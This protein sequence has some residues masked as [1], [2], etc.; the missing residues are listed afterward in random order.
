MDFYTISTLKNLELH[1]LGDRYFCLA[2]FYLQNEDYKNFFL[3]VRK[4]FPSAWIT[5]DNSS[6]EHSLVTEEALLSVVEELQ[7]NEVISPDV[8]FNKDQT[9][10]N[11]NSFVE[12]MKEFPNTEIFACPQGENKQAWVDCYKEMLGNKSVS[13]IGLSKIAVPFAFQGLDND[14]GIAESRQE[15]VQYLFDNNLIRKPLHFL[16]MGDPREYTYYRKFNKEIRKFFRSSDSCYTILSAV[17]GVDFFNGDFKR[18]P[19]YED[20][21]NHELTEQERTLAISNVAFLKQYNKGA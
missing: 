12:K 20:F 8:L 4:I 17:Q 5:L 3:S 2:H 11:L 18:I 15:A 16:G 1:H 7:P 13:T 9:L 21:Y 6:A 14:K 10:A 19:T